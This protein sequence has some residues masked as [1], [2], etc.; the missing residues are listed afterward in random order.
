MYEKEA[1]EAFATKCGLKTI[2]GE[3]FVTC[4]CNTVSLFENVDLSDPTPLHIYTQL[5]AGFKCL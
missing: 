4:F 2:L 1:L 3:L 5:L